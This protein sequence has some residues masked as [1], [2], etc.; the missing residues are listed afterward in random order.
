MPRQKTRAAF[1]LSGRNA[2]PTFGS[3]ET[4]PLMP[5]QHSLEQAPDADGEGGERVTGDQAATDE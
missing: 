3:G 2:P 4:C 1:G 5:L